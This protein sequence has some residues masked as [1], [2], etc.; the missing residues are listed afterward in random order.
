M[1]LFEAQPVIRFEDVS[2]FVVQAFSLP[3]LAGRTPVPQTQ[4]LF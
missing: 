1:R 2:I 4:S 3:F